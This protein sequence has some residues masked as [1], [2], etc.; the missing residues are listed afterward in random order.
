[1]NP[2]NVA[3]YNYAGTSRPLPQTDKW[4]GTGLLSK[5]D[6]GLFCVSTSYGQTKCNSGR[7]P[8]SNISNVWIENG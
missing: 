8:T 7:N 2:F 3:T 6:M 1:M 5:P 4:V